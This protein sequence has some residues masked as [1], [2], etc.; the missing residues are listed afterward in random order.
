MSFE[1]LQHFWHSAE[2]CCHGLAKVA[3]TPSMFKTHETQRVIFIP[4]RQAFCYQ[5][6]QSLVFL[7]V[8][9]WTKLLLQFSLFIYRHQIRR[10]IVSE[11]LSSVVVLYFLLHPDTLTMNRLVCFTLF[12]SVKHFHQRVS[13]YLTASILFSTKAI[14][15]VPAAEKSLSNTKLP[16]LCSEE[17]HYQ[18]VGVNGCF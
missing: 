15:S 12:R 5:S 8:D 1:I 2:Y 18:Q 6:I 17:L 9:L 4:S 7:F 13:L 10:K 11:L 16:L 14:L 3:R